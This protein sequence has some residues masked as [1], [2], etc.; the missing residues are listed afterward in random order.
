[1]AKHH[2][3]AAQYILAGAANFS[4][5]A[6]LYDGARG[7]LLNT[8]SYRSLGAALAIAAT[9]L[10][11]AATG[12]QLPNI[13]TITY[14]AATD[15]VA[16]LNGASK[17]VAANVK[18]ADGTTQ[19]VY[20]LDQPRNV[21][22]NATHGASLIAMTLLVSGYDEYGV[23]ISELFSITA[24][25][26]TKTVTGKKAFKW[27]LSYAFTSA[28]NATTN[29]ANVAWGNVFGL[30]YR[31]TEA[32]ACIGMTN[33]VPDYTQVVVAADDTNPPTSSTGDCRGTFTPSVA[34]DGV[35]KY[36]QWVIPSDPTT[37]AGLF[38][39]QAS[40]IAGYTGQ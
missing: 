4:R 27:I 29:T 33:G 38:G 26:T 7:Y 16:P 6:S 36:A 37:V 14:T 34:T 32:N 3:T 22:L 28:G 9:A 23:A 11:N 10:V 20:P 21:T 1:M 40:L 30:R 19:L 18:M 17:P 25:G 15:G 8:P 35:K 24:T 13:A 2:L 12:A 5:H 39:I 31:V